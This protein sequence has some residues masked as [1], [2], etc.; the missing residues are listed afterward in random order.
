MYLAAETGGAVFG[1][2]GTGGIALAA[3]VFLVLGVRGQGRVKLKDNPALISAFIAGTA[4][5][6]AGDIWL[7]PSK[8]TAQGLTGIGVGTG[9]GPFGDIGLGAVGLILLIVMLTAKMTPL[10]GAAL[11]LIASFVWPATGDGTIW[12]IPAELAAAVLMMVGS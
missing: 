12:A 11:G 5:T 2:L 3:T 6:A 10:F 4:F 1:A 9:G 8:I 7:N